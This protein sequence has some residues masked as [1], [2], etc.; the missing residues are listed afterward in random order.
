MNSLKKWA[1]N[2]FPNWL[3]TQFSM[4]FKRFNAVWTINMRN[5]DKREKIT[6]KTHQK[7]E[8]VTSDY[9]TVAYFDYLHWIHT[10][11][12]KFQISNQIFKIFHTSITCNISQNHLSPRNIFP[13]SSPKES[14]VYELEL[15]ESF[16]GSENTFLEWFRMV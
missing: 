13:F 2:F 8:F 4:R 11:F 5:W 15:T 12:V 6:K 1:F 16:P 10:F 14:L 7:S 9:A 3:K